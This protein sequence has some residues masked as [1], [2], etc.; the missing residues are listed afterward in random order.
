MVLCPDILIVTPT[1]YI[2]FGNTLKEEKQNSAIIWPQRVL[3]AFSK[4]QYDLGDHLPSASSSSSIMRRA[5]YTP[6]SSQIFALKEMK[7]QWYKSPVK[8][9]QPKAG[10]SKSQMRY[11]PRKLWF[12]PLTLLSF[13]LPPW[14]LNIIILP[15]FRWFTEA[16]KR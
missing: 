12:S 4:H 7:T 3:L 5:S 9:A 14:K 10:R 15:L 16:Q 13:S 6:S 1:H 2:K 11:L 8:I